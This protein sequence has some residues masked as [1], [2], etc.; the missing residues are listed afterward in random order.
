MKEAKRK[1]VIQKLSKEINRNMRELENLLM[2]E[3]DVVLEN[4]NYIPKKAVSYIDKSKLQSDR[5][6]LMV[7]ISD[8]ETV[9]LAVKKRQTRV[10]IFGWSKDDCSVLRKKTCEALDSSGLKYEGDGLT[11]EIFIL[12]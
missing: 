2:L 4:G 12:N 11:G 9:R 3:A 6:S 10:L 1:E 8:L 5:E 7:T